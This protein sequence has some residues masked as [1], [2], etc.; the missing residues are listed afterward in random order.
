MK[1][2]EL[3]SEDTGKVK[4]SEVTYNVNLSLITNPQLGDY[5][6]VHAGFAIEKLNKDEANKRIKLFKEL[7]KIDIHDEIH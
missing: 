6:L 3:T 7:A 5:V 1:I 4:A 2:I